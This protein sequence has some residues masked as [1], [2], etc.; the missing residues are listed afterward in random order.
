[1]RKTYLLSILLLCFFAQSFAQLRVYQ[2]GNVSVKSTLTTSSIPLSV[3][4]R[5]YGSSYNVSMAASNPSSGSTYNIGMEGWALRSTVGTTGRAIG[6]RG[7]AGNCT[8]GYNYGVLG[9]LQGTRNGAG[10]FGSATQVLGYQTD[11]KYAGFFHGDVKTTGVSKLNVA[12]PYENNILSTT[13]IQSA[14]SIISSIQTKQGVLP[15]PPEI[16]DTMY[17]RGDDDSGRPTVTHYALVPSSIA[18]LYPGLVQQDAAGNYF[19]S[20]TELVPVL[21]AAVQQLYAMVSAA[22]MANSQELGQETENMNAAM[23]Q[24][25]II[26]SRLW[27]NSPNPFSNSTVIRY[28]LQEG[29][30]DAWLY[31]FDMKGLLLRQMPLSTSS[32][33][34]TISG[35]DLQPG[36]Y[37]YSLIAD[38]READTKRMI[39]TR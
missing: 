13:A 6:V 18:T 25:S 27:Q 22:S 24:A 20:N 9:A 30:R 4:N 19:V 11:G 36:M 15:T 7:I 21:V 12:N 14:L 26:G 2:N 32:E 35:G 28:S 33:S 17:L 8:A 23:P 3:G 5:T 38:G 1:M 10:V 16:A 34:V 37:I 31:I 29:V 39:L